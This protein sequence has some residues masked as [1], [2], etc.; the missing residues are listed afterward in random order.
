MAD[1]MSPEQRS[2]RMSR[3]RGKDTLPELVVRKAVHALGFRFRLHAKSLPGR[4]DLVLPRHRKAVLVHGCFWHRHGVCRRATTPTSNAVFW[5]RKFA[6][7]VRRDAA[8]LAALRAAGWRVLVVWECETKD[9]ARLE[10]TLRRFLGR[11]VPV[12]RPAA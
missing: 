3:V 8:N 12:S 5:A 10:K 11:R 6:D 4:P 2:E 9:G 1:I 7:N